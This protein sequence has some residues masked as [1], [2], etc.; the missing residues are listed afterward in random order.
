MRHAWEAGD[1]R[2]A[3]VPITMEVTSILPRGRSAP[4]ELRPPDRSGG[5]PLE[6]CR[7]LR[8]VLATRVRL[9]LGGRGGLRLGRRLVRLAEVHAALRGPRRGR[10]AARVIARRAARG[11]RAL[12]LR[13]T[14]AL[15]VAVAIARAFTLA[16]RLLRTARSLA[17]RLGL[18]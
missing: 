12:S 11:R 8:L 16:W 15:A 6:E 4:A 14:V 5:A 1:R 10:S 13:S 9:G 7:D 18:T 3:R 17:A 2:C